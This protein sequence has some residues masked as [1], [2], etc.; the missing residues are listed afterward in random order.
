M[1]GANIP[2]VLRALVACGWFGIQTWI[3]GEAINTLLAALMST[4]CQGG[5][6][7]LNTW[8]PRFLT[9]ERHL[10][11][12]SSTGYLAALIIGSFAGYLVGAWFSDRFGRRKL[13]LTFSLGAIEPVQ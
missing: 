5:Y 13:F 10:S 12:L 9:T 7:A 2:A 1:L 6:Y 4:G 8:L 11:I 3:G